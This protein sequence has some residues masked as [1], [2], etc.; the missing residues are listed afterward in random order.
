MNKNNHEDKT[1]VNT[2]KESKDSKDKEVKVQEIK[3]KADKE[4]ADKEKAVKDIT[5]EKG[6]N[7]RKNK[8]FQHMGLKILSLFL[9]VIL[10]MIVM[11]LD[12]YSITRTIRNIHVEQ[13]N[14]DAIEELGKVY[15]V[16][17]GSTVDIVVK[18]PRSVV[19]SLTA[20]SF[21][22]SADL[23]EVS[24]TSSVQIN[25][26]P[27]DSRVAK[28]ITIT[29]VNNTMNL[30]IEDKIT[31]SL[32]IK[33]VADGDPAEYYALGTIAVTPNMIDISGPASIV[34]RVTEVRAIVSLEG[35]NES[36]S[37]SVIPKC[38]DAYGEAL[39]SKA[40]EL[41]VSTVTVKASVYPT[42]E[43][44]VKINTEGIPQAGVVVTKVNYNPKTVMVAG[45]TVALDGIDQITINDVSVE[46]ISENKELNIELDKYLPTGVYLA[47]A[48][49]EVAV[50]VEVEWLQEK[51][52]EIAVE[53][54]ELKGKDE[55]KFEYNLEISGV[56]KLK[57]RGLQENLD[58]VTKE[59]LKVYLNVE[60]RTAGTTDVSPSYEK[61]SGVTVALIGRMTLTVTEKEQP[62]EEP[63]E[64]GEGTGEGTGENTGTGETTGTGEGNG[65]SG[66][67]VPGEEN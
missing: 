15:D 18:G 5:G 58:P 44:P 25:V 64:E 39:N 14:G 2:I 30:T 23:S 67:A 3:E 10:W 59:S 19:D 31:R 34:S 24:I 43:V 16:I 41:G 13:L 8:L 32:P 22:A 26:T 40:I 37:E 38:I 52:I 6:S 51:V 17:D 48:N 53:D 55:E 35:A 56:Y 28:D 7:W 47:D 42:K 21:Y 46:G 27:I 57:L 20:D 49:E 12:D 45:D 9:A 4:K 54:I 65:T 33:A 1:P 61:P 66:A 11:N 62:T 29:Y 36:L 63:T 60:G 50:S